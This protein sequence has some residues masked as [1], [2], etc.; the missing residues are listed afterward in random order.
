MTATTALEPAVLTRPRR[1]GAQ[2][3][4]ITLGVV[5]VALGS[6]LAIGG[7]AVV[8]L[9]GTDGAI[10]SSREPV[11]TSS[12]ALVS[13]TATI[14]DTA[15]AADVIGEP[16][17]RISAEAAGGKDVF[18]GVAP[19]AQV[20]RYLAGAPVD[21]VTD[22][23]VDPFHLR[24]DAHPGTRT[25]APPGDQSFWVAEAIGTDSADLE[26][27]VR[28]G[29]YRF[30]I[31]NADGTRDVRTQSS[32][33]LEIPHLAAIGLGVGIAGVLMLLGGVAA[34]VAGTRRRY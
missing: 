22:V 34:V 5:L 12:A 23:D 33:E 7:G 15:G 11:S 19:A 18:V 29:D 28:D 14:E 20:E 10:T 3:A 16:R 13:E 21:E 32:F 24:R 27:R 8:A 6:V 1:S 31:M 4:A 9:F 25:P 17:I 30:V 2:V 26:W